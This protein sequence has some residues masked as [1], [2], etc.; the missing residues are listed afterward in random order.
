MLA[1]G[2]NKGME[3]AV[4][5]GYGWGLFLDDDVEISENLIENTDLLGMTKERLIRVKLQKTVKIRM[6]V[7]NGGMERAVL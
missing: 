1:S 2:R 3:A 7:K 6:L 5:L 4:D